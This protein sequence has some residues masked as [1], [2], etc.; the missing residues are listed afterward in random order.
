[1]TQIIACVAS[2]Q[3]GGQSVDLRIWASICAA[4]VSSP[5]KSGLSCPMPPLKSLAPSWT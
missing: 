3:Y 4:A 2:N 1:M 5:A